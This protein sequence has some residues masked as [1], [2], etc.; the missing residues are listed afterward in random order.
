MRGEPAVEP[1]RELVEVCLQ[2]HGRHGALMCCYKPPFEQRDNEVNMVKLLERRLGALR[3]NMRPVFETRRTK[4][5][6][7]RQTVRHDQGSWLD[8][9]AHKGLGG[10]GIGRLHASET[11]SPQLGRVPILW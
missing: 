3:H 11:D 8:A 2:M 5:V 9:V 7:D 1:K 4:P 10:F 6:V